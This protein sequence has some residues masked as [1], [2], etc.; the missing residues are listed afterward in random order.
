MAST[1]S[2]SLAR[3]RQ[4]LISAAP[5]RIIRVGKRGFTWGI[6]RT[7]PNYFAD[8]TVQVLG[9]ATK[10]VIRTNDPNKPAYLVKYAQKFGEQET[11]TEFFINQLGRVLGFGMAHSGL[12]RLDG[13]LAFLTRIFTSGEETLRHGS[14]VIEDYYEDIKALDRVRKDE[15]QAFYSVDFVVGILQQF[16]GDDFAAIFPRFIEMLIFDG[17]IGS[18]DRHAQ[19]WG[20]LARVTEPTR[21]RFAPI[22]DSARALF[23]SMDER[24]V[25]Q[26]LR[27]EKAFHAH[28]NRAKPCLGPVRQ[29]PK[30]NRCNHFEFIGNLH[31]LY[32]HPIEQA[33]RRLPDV[34]QIGARLLRQFPFETAF[35]NARKQLIE[36]TLR[37]RAER[38]KSFLGKG[39][40]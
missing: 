4:P 24:Q 5:T 27:D 37:V 35:S 36:K 10:W 33:I 29:H 7:F 38:I 20:V 11:Y 12:V 14:L 23:W 16:C 31:M 9:N 8:T 15:E 13:T 21:Y 32:R 18:M 34:G 22:F 3:D 26:L 28:L 2:S 40:S 17:V 1:R 30:V 6:P 25:E 39:D 19:N